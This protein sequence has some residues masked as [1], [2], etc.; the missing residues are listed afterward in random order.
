MYIEEGFQLEA[1]EWIHSELF[2]ECVGFQPSF[3][4]SFDS[5]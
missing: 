5:Y 4:R 3:C 2:R 1:L